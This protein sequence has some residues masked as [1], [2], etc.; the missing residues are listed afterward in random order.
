MTMN[1]LNALLNEGGATFKNGEIVTYESGY[2]VAILYDTVK[3]PD[4]EKTRAQVLYEINNGDLVDGGIWFNP[5]T[6]HIELDLLTV[7]ISDE[8]D[9]RILGKHFNQKAIFDWSV[10]DTIYLEDE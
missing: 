3:R 10:F 4:N 8:R 6:K 7:N 5:D 2:Q 1:E 9:A